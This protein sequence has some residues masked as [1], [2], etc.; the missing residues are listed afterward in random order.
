MA[1]PVVLKSR[2]ME[3]PEALRTYIEK[4]ASKLDRYLPDITEVRIDLSVQKTRSSQDR[5]V[6][7]ITVRSNGVILRA[8]ER[9]DE[10]SVAIDAVLE[11]M[12][13][14][15][16]R[17]K[18]KRL[19]RWQGQG[20]GRVDSEMPPLAEEVLEELAEEEERRI[21]R[22]KRFF[23]SPMTEEEAI[24]QMELLGHDFF[25]FY[26]P[27]Q[28]MLKVLYRRRDGNYGLLEPQLG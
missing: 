27:N 17:Y 1:V 20:P 3:I 7:Q 6:A 22:V 5:Q 10:M 23:V 21:V 9:A 8:E 24:E 14:Q 12:Y 25:I 11:K 26:N 16:A 18:G 28:G 4:R 13:R 2:N 15:I 19:N